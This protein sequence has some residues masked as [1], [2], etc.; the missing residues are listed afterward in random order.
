MRMRREVLPNGVIALN[1]AY[2]ANPQSMEASLKVLAACP[3][4]RVAV[5]GD[6][7]ELGA[8]EAHWH[9]KIGQLAVALRL[10]LVVLI[11]PL[12]GRATVPEAT[13]YAQVQDAVEPL[14]SYLRAGDH[15]LVKGSRGARMERILQALR[16]EPSSGDP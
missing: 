5:L 11:G 16:D 12:M 15:V 13:A 2:N 1:D 3:G 6:M 8:D 4:R 10:D 7:L 14:R 9:A